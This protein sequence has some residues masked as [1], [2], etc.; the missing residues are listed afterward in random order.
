MFVEKQMGGLQALL[1]KKPGL[2][3]IAAGSISLCAQCGEPALTRE[4]KPAVASNSMS[5]VLKT[6]YSQV[7]HAKH[8]VTRS[9][10]Q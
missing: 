6:G 2:Q 7:L 9:H 3:S 8:V 1:S 4:S 10:G 5:V